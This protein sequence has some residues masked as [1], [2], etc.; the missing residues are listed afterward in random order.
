MR[1]AGIHMKGTIHSPSFYW[2]W[3][4]P[5]GEL[6]L[7]ADAGGLKGLN[8][9]DGPHPLTPDP[10]WKEMRGPFQE[11]IQQLEQ[12]FAGKLRTFTI[13][14][15]LQGTV[16]QLSV[17]QALRQIPYGTTA[18]YGDIAGQM[19]NPKA[20]RAVGA[21]NGQNP[22]SIIV[23]CHRVIGKKGDMVGYG[24]GLPIKK[25]LLKLERR[26]SGQGVMKS[27]GI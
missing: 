13:K 22:I 2:T 12:Y 1:N 18:S 26:E 15:S 24:G 7:I 19:E 14:L 9:Q 17:W 20:C 5:V 11:V 8:F 23:P 16:F 25:I 21:A 27:F 6:L 10:A 3:S 4:S